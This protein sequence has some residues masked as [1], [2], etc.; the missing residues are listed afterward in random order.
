MN[1]ALDRESD[2]VLRLSREMT[3]AYLDWGGPRHGDIQQGLYGDMID[4]VNFRV[5][6]AQSCLDL[7][8]QRRVADVLCLCRVL[9]EHYLLF[10]LMCRGRRFFRLLPLESLSNDDFAE[11]LRREVRDWESKRAAG[12]PSA[13]VCASTHV[14]SATSCTSSRV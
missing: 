3:Q 6:T 2:R 5:E 13:S 8:Q 10:M 12:Q 7:I 1:S 14:R 11:R 4:F 9:L